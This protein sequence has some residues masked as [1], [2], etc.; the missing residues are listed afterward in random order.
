ME[1]PKQGSPDAE[2]TWELL[3]RRRKAR[4]GGDCPTV[5]AV[6]VHV[7]CNRR[8]TRAAIADTPPQLILCADCGA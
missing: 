2:D 7:L 1:Q 6:I 8:T 4:L 3:H 5:A